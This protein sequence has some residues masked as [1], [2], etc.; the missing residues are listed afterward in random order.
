[1]GNGVACTINYN[2]RIAATLYTIETW[3][4][5]YVIVNTLRKDN[6]NNNNNNL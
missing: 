4:D 6:N 1:M 5:K 3:L 2:Y